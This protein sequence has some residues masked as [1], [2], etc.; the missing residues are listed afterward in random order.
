MNQIGNARQATTGMVAVGRA[1]ENGF[2]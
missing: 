2:T 1:Q